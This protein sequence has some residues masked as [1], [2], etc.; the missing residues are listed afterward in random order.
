MITIKKIIGVLAPIIGGI[1]VGLIISGYI[2]YQDLVKPPLAP[3]KIIFPIAWTILYILMG[4]SYYL[5]SKDNDTDDFNKIY[6]LQLF[7][8]LL[9]PIIF[10]VFNMYFTAF[11][12]LVLLMILVIIMIK[13]LA[14]GKK[15]AAYLQIPY[16]LWLFYAAY[17]NFFIAIL[18]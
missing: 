11:F 13:E 5:F 1:V 7:V 4:I 16:L 6:Y 15:L 14:R 8:N 17:L 18:N 3:R 10:F 9:W 12:W 2:N